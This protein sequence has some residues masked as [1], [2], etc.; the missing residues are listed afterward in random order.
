M[1]AVIDEFDT[2]NNCLDARPITVDGPSP[3]VGE[4]LEDE[5]FWRLVMVHNQGDGGC[6]DQGT[7]QP[8]D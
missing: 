3:D 1:D 4:I 2:T 5:T 8:F 6:G 7:A